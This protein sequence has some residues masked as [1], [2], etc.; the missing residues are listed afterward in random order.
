MEHYNR[1]SSLIISANPESSYLGSLSANPAE[2]PVRIINLGYEARTAIRDSRQKIAAIFVDPSYF[3]DSVVRIIELTRQHRPATPVFLMYEDEAPLP[4]EEMK[5][6]GIQ[7]AL[8]KP[9]PPEKI[10]HWLAPEVFRS[11]TIS[12]LADTKNAARTGSNT[13]TTPSG[14]EDQRFTAVPITDFLT[15]TSQLFDV[16]VRLESGRYL[17]ISEATDRLPAERVLS[18]IEKGARTLYIDKEAHGRSIQYV[19]MFARV[20][21]SSPGISKAVKLNHTL[22][23]A[24]DIVE[25]IQTHGLLEEHI[26]DIHGV[27]GHIRSTI[28]K[29]DLRKE[30]QIRDFLNNLNS[31]D[32]AISCTLVTSM[33]ALKMN[34][35]SDAAFKAVGL[36]SFLH[37][38]GLLQLP[39]EVRHEFESEMSSSQKKL[40]QTHPELSAKVVAA[41]PGVTQV[42]LQAIEQH[43]ERRNGQGFP[44]K[45][46]GNTVSPI[47]E[48]IGLSEEFIR[49]LGQNKR[50]YRTSLKKMQESVLP[51]FSF[52]VAD[53]FR[54]AFV[55]RM[56][57]R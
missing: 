36:A 1:Y 56:P 49:L 43:H 12:L 34:I 25:A 45:I 37:D 2:F 41:I 29:L 50:D 24:Q 10:Q 44:K 15:G 33:I 17:K 53:G 13:P 19:K 39:V 14:T 20:L 32:H 57:G 28:E 27:L 46:P 6:L 54:K 11:N 9:L 22:S 7:A 38:I 21:L 51:L 47:A 30:N 55:K 8:A 16:F 52:P 26:E 3:N 4:I 35:E 23:R 48:I 31:F 5:R 40:Y 18:Y 42:T